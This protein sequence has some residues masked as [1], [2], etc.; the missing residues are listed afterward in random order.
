MAKDYYN[1][2]LKEPKNYE[3]FENFKD[4]TGHF[5]LLTDLNVPEMMK[6]IKNGKNNEIENNDELIEN[7]IKVDNNENDEIEIKIDNENENEIDK[8][9]KNENEN[10]I[11][12]NEK[13]ENKI[14]KN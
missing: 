9:E 14:E 6:N 5:E 1:I 13:N 7:K 10:K 12:N 2:K 11:D 8:S 4:E 3:D